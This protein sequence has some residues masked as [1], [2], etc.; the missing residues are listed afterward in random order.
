MPGWGAGLL[1]SSITLA[2]T[3]SIAWLAWSKRV[4][5]LMARTQRTLK[6]DLQWT[7]ERVA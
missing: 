1:V 2:A 5:K 4:R 3:A 7:K 6:D